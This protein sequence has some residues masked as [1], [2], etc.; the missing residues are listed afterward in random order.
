MSNFQIK[1]RQKL[2]IPFQYAQNQAFL[3]VHTRKQR[4]NGRNTKTK[5]GLML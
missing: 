5:T 3:F 4:G 1:G 2:F